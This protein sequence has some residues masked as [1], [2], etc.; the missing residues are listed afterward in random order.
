M[1]TLKE[2]FNIFLQ[3]LLG[4]AIG[5]IALFICFQLMLMNLDEELKKQLE[6]L[7]LGI[8]TTALVVDTGREQLGVGRSSSST[9]YIDLYLNDTDKMV[10]K[11]TNSTFISEVKQGDTINVVII[12]VNSKK[13]YEIND[14]IIIESEN[15]FL[16][17]KD[18]KTEVI[19]LL[20]E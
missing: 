15:I 12:D 20:K 8:E 11:Y 16:G 4:L 5:G 13:N 6:A 9:P 7:K 1:S 10:R 17:N 2:T 3:L 14:K 18:D 19:R